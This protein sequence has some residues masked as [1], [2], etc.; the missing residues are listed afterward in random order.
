M[1]AMGNKKR[2][3]RN[4]YWILVSAVA[5]LFVSVLAM[6]MFANATE[7]IL[8]SPIG[9]LILYILQVFGSLSLFLYL[10]STLCSH[11]EKKGFI[12]RKECISFIEKK[13]A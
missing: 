9:G 2:E 13:R 4:L 11:F 1:I 6:L 10:F 5:S 8:Y 3:S 7:N 12:N